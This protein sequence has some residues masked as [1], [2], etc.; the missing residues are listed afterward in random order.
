MNNIYNNLIKKKKPVCVWGAGYIGLSTL[1]FYAKNGFY[2][3]GFDIN[4]RYINDLSKGKLKNDDFKKWL[5]FEIKPLIKKKKLRFTN[6]ILEVKKFNPQIHF[7]CIPTE[8]NGKPLM[9]ILYQT[10]RSIIKILD[11]RGIIIIESTLTPGTGDLLINK[12]LRKKDTN[13]KIDFVV[14]PRRDWF[15]DG[16]KNLE[17]M[18]RIFGGMNKKSQILGKKIL[19][20]VC[21]KLHKASS[22]KVAEMVK[23]FEN[24]YRHVDIAL[25]NQLSKAFPNENIRETL[26]LVGTKWNIG[27]FYPGFGSGGY[28][29]PLS[30]KYVISGAKKKKELTILK[31]T[32][33]T[34]TLI[35]TDIAK[36]IVRKKLKKVGIIGLSY[37]ANLKV[38]TLSP[39]LPFIKYLKNKKIL[40]NLY[41]P[42]YSK[43]EIKQIADVKTFKFPSEIN[44]F[45]CLVFHVKHKIF[46]KSYKK[47][48]NNSKLKYLI[49]NTGAF[50]KF[51]NILI[52]RGTKYILTGGR[53]WL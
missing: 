6:D 27:T 43:K 46:D 7:V 15:V 45:D 41:D 49:D 11:D 38:H 8:K 32:I 3:L 13:K 36:S 28:C 14:A 17:N 31:E 26:K 30:S 5:G 2:A 33:K 34:D 37:K 23:S 4:H 42:Y 24:C 52:K 1:A 19:S 9:K 39:I 29:I 47:I 10:I 51:N 44:K 18:D 50:N 22:H 48:S 16:T 40:V 53:N 35:N 21:R 25:A 20:L 12:F